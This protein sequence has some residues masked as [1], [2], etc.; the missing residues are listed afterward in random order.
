MLFV[1]FVF[2]VTF[3]V[4]KLVSNVWLLKPLTCVGLVDCL[5]M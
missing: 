5:V 4:P 2:L 3:G 1:F